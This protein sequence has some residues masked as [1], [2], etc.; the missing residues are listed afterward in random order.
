MTV[1]VVVIPDIYSRL[2]I[3]IYNIVTTERNQ[4]NHQA[5]PL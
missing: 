4:D 3:Y 1:N 5:H 2:Y